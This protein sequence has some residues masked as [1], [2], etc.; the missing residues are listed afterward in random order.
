MRGILPFEMFDVSRGAEEARRFAKLDNIYHRGQAQAWNGREILDELWKRHGGTGL[1]PH[2]RDAAARVLGQIMWG[3]LAAWKI[4][5]QLSDELDDL[6]ARMAA[7]SQ[8]H[9]EARHFYV[10]HDYLERA[11]GTFPKSVARASEGL[12]AAA[13][14]ADSVE[15]KLLGMQ[16]QIE[17]MALTIFH[18]LREANVCPVLTDLLRYYERDEARHVGLGMQ[19]LPA[20]MRRFSVLDRVQ[21]TAFSFKVA[22]WSIGTLAQSEK[23]LR[24]LGVEPR[25]VA[26]LG[27]SKQMLVFNELFS[28]VPDQRNQTSERIGNVLDTVAELMWPQ[29]DADRSIKQRVRRAMHTLREGYGMVETQLDPDEPARMPKVVSRLDSN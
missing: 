28:I 20:R 8:A 19:L 16:L 7:T 29:S 23:D 25:R 26:A 15:K 5:A 18:A 3:E 6:E 12:L 21:F 24:I 14:H 22:A 9:D 11:V 13:L 2:Q 1:K 4:A 10:M 17:A 27:K